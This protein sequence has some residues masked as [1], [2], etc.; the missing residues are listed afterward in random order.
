MEE[1]FTGPNAVRGLVG[2]H[3][4]KMSKHRR[5]MESMG[6]AVSQTH[7]GNPQSFDIPREMHAHY[8][9]AGSERWIWHAAFISSAN[10]G[11]KSRDGC[12]V[13]LR[14][15]I[16]FA[17]KFRIS[18]IVIHTGAVSGVPVEKVLEGM[19]QFLLNEGIYHY[20]RTRA[21]KLAIELGASTCGLNLNPQTFAERFKGHLSVGW[22]LDLA[23]AYAAGCPW[24]TL[25][26]AIRIQPP[27]VCHANF[28]G[29]P[30]GSS[31][32][33]HGW[34]SVPHME[35]QGKMYSTRMDRTVDHLTEHFDITIKMLHEAGVPL[36]V[37]G[38]GFPG[39]STQTEMLTINAI[40]AGEKHGSEN[41]GSDYL[42]PG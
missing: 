6:Y 13:Y 2:P 7:F 41:E 12:A 11:E 34:R 35:K 14:E 37:E 33:I 8:D 28:P 10:P 15:V 39:C 38:S 29:S 24:K 1:L 19:D 30:F 22:C 20:L 36:I 17:E 5:Y 23:H 40:L 27:L 9:E 32:D 21:V 25:W 26:E 4:E 18:D 31:R 16:K 3:C 42:R